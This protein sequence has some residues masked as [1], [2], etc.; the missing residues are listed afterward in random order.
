MAERGCGRA[1][2]QPAW[3]SDP[4]YA[5]RAD[6]LPRAESR[7]DWE[8]QSHHPRRPDP[9]DKPLSPYRENGLRSPGGTDTGRWAPVKNESYET[10]RWRDEREGRGEEREERRLDRHEG[11]RGGEMGWG[12]DHRQDDKHRP[13]DHGFDRGE[14]RGN[15]DDDSRNDHKGLDRRDYDNRPDDGYAKRG[16]ATNFF[17]ANA[18]LAPS[19]VQRDSCEPPR[20]TLY[21]GGYD[22]ESQ[23]RR[24]NWSPPDLRQAL[25]RPY[26]PTMLGRTDSSMTSD[27]ASVASSTGVSREPTVDGRVRVCIQNRLRIHQCCSSLTRARALRRNTTYN[28]SLLS[29]R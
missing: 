5:P 7:R 19:L 4:K 12:A 18:H 14:R 16:D 24:E 9:Q 23:P 2:T 26:S 13:M 21:G 1:N 8:P 3:M 10:R 15:R 28:G 22:G 27:T 29:R 11:G 25:P 6:L 20:D 17:G